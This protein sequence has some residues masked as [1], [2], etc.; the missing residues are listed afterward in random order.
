M[1]IDR[2]AP[3]AALEIEHPADTTALAPHTGPP[4]TP[5]PSPVDATTEL[6][7]RQESIAAIQT[8]PAVIP[9]G[10]PATVSAAQGGAAADART[11]VDAM[12]DPVEIGS[13]PVVPWVAPRAGMHPVMLTVLIAAILA[14]LVTGMIVAWNLLGKSTTSTGSRA[15]PAPLQPAPTAATAAKTPPPTATIVLETPVPEEVKVLRSGVIESIPASERAVKKTEVITTLKGSQ[16]LEA[17]VKEM[18]DDLIRERMLLDAAIK[19]F[20]TEHAAGHEDTATAAQAAIIEHRKLIERTQLQLSWPRTML[21]SYRVRAPRDG[22]F[23]PSARLDDTVAQDAVIGTL[24]RDAVLVATFKIG[25]TSAFAANASVEILL[26][27]SKRQF[28]LKE[29]FVHVTCTIAE[30]QSDSV[31]VVCPPDPELTEGTIVRL[32]DPR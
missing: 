3:Y 22:R 26:L 23:V 19:V 12:P 18:I 4:Q 10:R 28:A 30:V 16:P 29:Y 32:A 25:H 11:K 6:A 5:A 17:Q 20:D 15:A 21:D 24:V 14:V 8:T 7:A 31:K 13:R 27:P 9:R 1:R 2:D